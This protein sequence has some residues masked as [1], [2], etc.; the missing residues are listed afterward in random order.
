MKGQN[1]IRKTK[2]R[3]MERRYLSDCPITDLLRK[4]AS[5]HK[6]SLKSD[7]RLLSYDQKTIFKTAAVRHL[8]F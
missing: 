4:T 5:S 6:I 7:N 3:S 2:I 8:E 1:C